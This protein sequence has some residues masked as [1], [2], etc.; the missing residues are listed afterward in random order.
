MTVE[1][2]FPWTWSRGWP[3]TRRLPLNYMVDLENHM[4][5]VDDV[6][7]R[8]CFKRPAWD[9]Y[10]TFKTSSRH[11]VIYF[12]HMGFKVN[13]VVQGQSPGSRSTTGSSS[14]KPTLYS[15]FIM[16]SVLRL[17]AILDGPKTTLSATLE[18]KILCKSVYR[19]PNYSMRTEGRTWTKLIVAFWMLW[20]CRKS[21]KDSIPLDRLVWYTQ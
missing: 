4:V 15:H 2:G 8:W 18:Y 13:H 7:A 9:P 17:A 6:I 10:I 14:R 1:C 5:E 3:W 16:T 21:N 11:Y 20:T 12:N 19:K